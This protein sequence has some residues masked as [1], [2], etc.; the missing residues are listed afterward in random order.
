MMRVIWV[1]L[2]FVCVFACSD[3]GAEPAPGRS[4]S[5]A[6]QAGERASLAGT[7][8]DAQSSDPVPGARVR[9]PSG[10]EATTDAQ[11]RFLIEGLEPGLAGELRAWAE[12]GREAV[13]TLRPLRPGRLE[14]VL[15]IRLP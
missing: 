8:L 7:V 3:R 11:G 6:A 14:V 2:V 5:A 13:S 10:A 15:R 4:P 12:D 9:A 1:S